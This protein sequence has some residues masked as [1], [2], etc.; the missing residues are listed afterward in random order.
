MKIKVAVLQYDCPEEAKESVVR[1]E[2][3]V[4]Q[5]AK[6]G[7]KLVVAPE[8][9]VGEAME[10][11]KTGV[12]YLPDLAKIARRHKVYLATSYYKKDGQKFVEQ[13][14]AVAPDGKVVVDHRKMYLAKPEMEDLG[15]QGGNGL[16]VGQSGAGK[17]G[18]L[19]CKDGF[20]RYSHFLYERFGELGVEIICV[21]SWFIG[22]KEL[23]THQY[24]KGL[25][26]Y[27]AFAS[28]AFVLV[29]GSLNE[30]LNSFGRSLIISPVRGV[31]KEGSSDKEEILV[32]ELD[33]NEV[34][35]ARKF[36]SWWQ[37]KERII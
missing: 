8:T 26:T 24:I 32:E 31:L 9:A 27:G 30:F 20:N 18:M 33:L 34:N 35:K 5:A 4:G 3:M 11:K 15:V 36:D 12:D 2:E 28:R 7:A 1:L 21:P 10:T 16:K 6:L 23:D 37:P 25:F 19:M 13:G 22:W 14:Y 29:S 17:L